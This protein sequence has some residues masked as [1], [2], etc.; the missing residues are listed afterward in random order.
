MERWLP[1]LSVIPSART[2]GVLAP[3]LTPRWFSAGYH[4]D[5]LSCG[6]DFAMD[7]SL[8]HRIAHFMYTDFLGTAATVSTQPLLLARTGVKKTHA[9]VEMTGEDGHISWRK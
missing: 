1:V 2:V 6:S 7:F 3:G 5:G 8:A 4:P 9:I